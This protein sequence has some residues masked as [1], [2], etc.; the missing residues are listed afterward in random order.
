MAVACTRERVVVLHTSSHHF[1]PRKPTFYFSGRYLLLHRKC[2]FKR[3]HPRRGKD[4]LGPPKKMTTAAAAAERRNELKGAAR[5][6]AIRSRSEMSN[7]EIA[8]SLSWQRDVDERDVTTRHRQCGCYWRLE[9]R[10]ESIEKKRSPPNCY[11]I[12]IKIT[13]VVRGIVSRIKNGSSETFLTIYSA[14]EL[15][16]NSQFWYRN[17]L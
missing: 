12:A 9:S 6:R 4:A 1:S 5:M 11:K 16:S 7:L 10:K 17:D 15:A 2:C 3:R 13:R 14:H 8:E